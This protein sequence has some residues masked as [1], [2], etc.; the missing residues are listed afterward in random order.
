MYE[1]LVFFGEVHHIDCN[2]V[3]FLKLWDFTDRYWT[4]NT[5]RVDLANIELSVNS[6]RVGFA[7]NWVY[8]HQDAPHETLVILALNIN[9][10]LLVL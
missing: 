7:E 4:L 1:K 2:V 6:L 9:N 8:G 10:G 3:L 5:I